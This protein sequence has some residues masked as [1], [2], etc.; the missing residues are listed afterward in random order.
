MRQ[1]IISARVVSSRLTASYL[2]QEGI[3]IIRSKRDSNFLAMRQGVAGVSWDSG[4]AGG[5]EVLNLKI[6]FTRTMTITHQSS[7]IMEV[8]SQIVWQEGNSQHEVVA[9]ELLY[10]WQ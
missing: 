2:A 7:D 5:V 9:K 8:K 1:S 4:I 10:K 3:E 6:S